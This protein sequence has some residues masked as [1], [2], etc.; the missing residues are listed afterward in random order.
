MSLPT[1]ATV[2]LAKV[3]MGHSQEIGIILFRFPNCPIIYPVGPVYY[4]PGQTSNT[5]SLGDLKC[6]V[7]FKNVTYEPLEY[8]GFVDPQG[9]Y[10]GPP[11]QTQN[12]VYYL[13]IK[14][15][16]FKTHINSKFFVPAGFGS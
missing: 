7:C 6:Y 3:N 4:F 8:C 11:Y 15:F 14:N 9:R 2:E 16:K 13:Q 10:W 1:K 12:N 5:I